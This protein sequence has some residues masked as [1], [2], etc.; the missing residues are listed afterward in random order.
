MKNAIRFV[1]YYKKKITRLVDEI[2][3]NVFEEI[4]KL[5]ECFNQRKDRIYIVG[6]GGSAATASH[7]QNDIGVGLKRR[8]ILDLNIISL[9]DNLSVVT[10]LA[11]DVGYENIFYSQLKDRITK[12]D[13]L[14]AIS[15]SGD[16]ENIIKAVEY[17]K[18]N[19]STVLGMT[20]FDG[21][22]L[23]DLS[24]I[25][26]HI[27]TEKDEYGLVEDLHMILDHMLYTYFIE[28]SSK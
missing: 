11:N 19:G 9:C 28:N 3:S 2:D 20:G 17:A 5:L 7:M 18:K 25:S 23:K 8:G 10:A 6:N 15:C 14:I 26:Y 21:G 24:D 27:Q 16:S 4:I 13:L 12:N 1:E 22:K